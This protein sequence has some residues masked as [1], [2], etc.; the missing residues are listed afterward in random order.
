MMAVKVAIKWNWVVWV[1][2]HSGQLFAAVGMSMLLS[3]I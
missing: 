3:T 1:V 2:L